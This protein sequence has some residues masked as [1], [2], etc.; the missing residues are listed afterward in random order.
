MTTVRASLS[1]S[2]RSWGSSLSEPEAEKESRG[3]ECCLTTLVEDVEGFVTEA[4]GGEVRGAS[5]EA[6]VEAIEVGG[7][8]SSAASSH[9]CLFRNGFRLNFVASAL[10]LEMSSAEADLTTLGT[11]RLLPDA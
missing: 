2:A 7:S 6:A 3:C 11:E 5:L 10:T 1:L 9:C 8:L 4:G